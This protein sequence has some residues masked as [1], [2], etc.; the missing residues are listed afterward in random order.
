MR[1]LIAVIGVLLSS[2]PGVAQQAKSNLQG[3]TV[4]AV[5]PGS[6]VMPSSDTSPNRS[7]RVVGPPPPLVREPGSLLPPSQTASPTPQQTVAPPPNSG[8]PSPPLRLQTEGPSTAALNAEPPPPPVQPQDI[9]PPQPQQIAADPPTIEALPPEPALADAPPEHEPAPEIAA[10][11]PPDEIDPPLPA[12]DREARRHGVR[13]KDIASLEGVRENQLIGYGLVVGLQGTGDT[14]RNAAFAEQS[15][16]SMLE[17]LGVNVRDSQLRTRNVAAVLVTAELPAFAGTG[18]RIDVSVASLGDATSLQGGTLIVTPLAGAD[19]HVYA[20]GQGPVAVGGFD[21]RGQA[22]S[23]TRG[24]PTTGRIPNGA[25]IEQQLPT[26]LNDI[27]R[28]TLKLKNPDFRT[29]VRITD[30]INDFSM[31]TY[32]A[33]VASEL[34]FRSVSLVKPPDVSVAR[35]I[36]QVEGL[37]VRPDTPARIVV[38]ERTGTVVMGADVRMS[39]VAITHG[40]L[41]IRVTEVPEVSQPE[42]FSDGETVVVPRTMVDAS[43]S[44]G[45]L[46]IVSGADL[47][48][49]VR[50]LNQIGL[51]PSGIIAIIQAMKT[52]GALQADLVI[53]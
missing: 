33:K 2:I 30:A 40:N 36:A 35:F 24:T 22:E 15:L 5:V 51:K 29:A 8:A 48:T 27:A 31:R 46:A 3:A 49:L 16:Q 43:E 17:R 1:F 53:Q 14:L 6:P 20:V 21:A 50:G 47:Q 52:A 25:V 11:P 23:V 7:P 44:G 39:T 41:T 28:L 9:A 32:A 37:V 12:I 18:M 13:I 45:R 34:D 4:R 26:P 19:G 38:D 42:P 10:L